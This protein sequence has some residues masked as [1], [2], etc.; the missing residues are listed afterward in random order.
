MFVEVIGWE[1]TV[2]EDYFLSVVSRS[3]SLEE[4]SLLFEPLAGDPS[5]Q[6]V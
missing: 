3:T 4:K 5:H 6:S 2:A 1:K